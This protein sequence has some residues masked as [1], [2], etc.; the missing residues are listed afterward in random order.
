MLPINTHDVFSEYYLDVREVRCIPL[1]PLQGPFYAEGG[2]L[3]LNTESGVRDA[4]YRPGRGLSWEVDKRRRFARWMAKQIGQTGHKDSTA[5]QATLSYFQ[6]NY[7]EKFAQAKVWHN[8]HDG[9]CISRGQ[10]FDFRIFNTDTD[11]AVG[12]TGT[13]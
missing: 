3:V 12:A 10:D 11:A 4:V 2:G 5:Y 7:I 6:T 13:C 8:S 1:L 9:V